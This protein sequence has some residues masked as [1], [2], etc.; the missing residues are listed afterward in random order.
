VRNI[1]ISVSVYLSVRSH[2]SKTTRPNFINFLCML[3][4]AVARFSSDGVS[5]PL[6]TSGFVD[7]V[8]FSHDGF[9]ALCVYS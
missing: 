2:N 7:D 1:A 5:I 9:L 3:L 6:C 8:M 4:V